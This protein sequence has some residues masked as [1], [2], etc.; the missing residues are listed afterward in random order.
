VFGV[1]SQLLDTLSLLRRVAPEHLVLTELVKL[2]EA[3]QPND[4]EAAGLEFWTLGWSE[5]GSI[6]VEAQMTLEKA[7]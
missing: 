2:D 7:Q 3:E 1:R 4:D 5:R 6:A